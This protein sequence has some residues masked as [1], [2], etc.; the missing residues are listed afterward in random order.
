MEVL[1]LIAPESLK[2]CGNLLHFNR[3]DNLRFQLR[4]MEILGNMAWLATAF[5]IEQ[6]FDTLSSIQDVDLKLEGLYMLMRGARESNKIE[7]IPF[8]PKIIDLSQ[9]MREYRK[10]VLHSAIK[11]YIRFGKLEEAMSTIDLIT[12]SSGKN[13]ALIDLAKSYANIDSN[14]AVQILNR[15]NRNY[16]LYEE[17]MIRVYALID[18]EKAQEICNQIRDPKDKIKALFTISEVLK[19]ESPGSNSN[20]GNHSDLD[21]ACERR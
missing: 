2:E 20:V 8:I 7:I 4:K 1:G 14:K 21:T 19:N 15:V 6:I 10:H 13:L 18:L 3:R 9:N 11:T 5:N 16:D 17:L 12:N